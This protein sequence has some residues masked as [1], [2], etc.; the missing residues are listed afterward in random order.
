MREK[1]NKQRGAGRQRC[2]VL[3]GWKVK[4]TTE[5]GRGVEREGV[6]GRE[7]SSGREREELVKRNKNLE[8]MM[9]RELKTRPSLNIWD[10]LNQYFHHR[11]KKAAAFLT[12]CIRSFNCQHFVQFV[13]EDV[14]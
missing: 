3:T 13:M 5:G 8:T 11:S 9:K 6:G 10:G 12:C 4:I 14:G 7:A 2:P 1:T